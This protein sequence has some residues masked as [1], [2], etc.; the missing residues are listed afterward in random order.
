M[1]ETF[2]KQVF[3]LTLY[4]VLLTAVNNVFAQQTVRGTV[5][6]EADEGMPGVNVV[7]KG[8]TTGTTTDADG[9]FSISVPGPES[10]LVVSFVGYNTEEISVG[11]QSQI[12]VKL[13]PD[14]ASLQEVVVIGYGT[15]RKQDV[16]TAV[17]QVKPNEFVPGAVRNAG[18]LLRGKVA[19]LT[20]STSS[21]DP[22][23]GTEIL[24]RGITSIY[25]SSSPLV[26]VDGYPGDMNSISP[27][28][29]ESIDVLKDASASAIYGTRGKNGVILITTKKAK[30]GLQPVIEY[31]GYVATD[32]FNRKAKFM[33]ASDVRARIGE[34]LID[35]AY[36]KGSSTD[37]LDEISRAPI[38]HF[39]R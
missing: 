34:G 5:L 39:T 31:A 7:L 20:L 18:E 12:D 24:L 27:N 38:N 2:T 11:S 9:K 29:I 4:I 33:N 8:T 23:A 36:D 28:D 1:K 25:G 17:A 35:P 22:D 14:I 10:V 32:R 15:Q 19:G 21:G 3:R 13:T 30:A 6:S 26:L 37:W 16:T